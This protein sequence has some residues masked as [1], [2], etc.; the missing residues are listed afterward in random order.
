MLFIIV[1]ADIV[2]IP[3]ESSLVCEFTSNRTKVGSHVFLIFIDT[4]MTGKANEDKVKLTAWL[5]SWSTVF[6]AHSYLCGFFIVSPS[7]HSIPKAKTV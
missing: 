1:F 7:S 6:H 5:G 2:H 3:L 4:T